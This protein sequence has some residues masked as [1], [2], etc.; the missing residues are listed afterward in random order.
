MIV[1]FFVIPRHEIALGRGGRFRPLLDRMLE[2]HVHEQIH[3]LGLDHQGAGGLLFAG[4]EM[5]VHAVVMNNRDITGLPIVANAVVDF[6]AR[7]IENI[8]RRLVY[9]SVL[10]GLATR[11]ILLEMNVKRLGAPVLRLDIVPAEM[12]RATVEL[13]I[14]SLDNARQPP[15]PIEFLLET[16]GAGEGAYENPLPIR[17][18]LLVAH[19]FPREGAS[20]RLFD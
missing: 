4:V 13:E 10:L 11:R 3:R 8:E 9:V 19:A 1:V 17:V 14:L 15:Q 5:L 12:L 7:A 2:Q 16:I 20:S 18:M 6:V